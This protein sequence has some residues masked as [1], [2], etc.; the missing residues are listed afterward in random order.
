[1]VYRSPWTPELDKRLMELWLI[2]GQT[3]QA[4]GDIIG[5][6]KHSVFRRLKRMGLGDKKGD[7]FS[8]YQMMGEIS[9][10]KEPHFQPVRHNLP[11]RRPPHS[12]STQ[13]T[14]LHWSDVHFPFHDPRAVNI[15]YQINEDLKPDTLVCHGD[16]A[17]MWQLSTHRPPMETKLRAD[18]IDIQE[19]LDMTSE[20][21]AQMEAIANPTWKIFMMGNHEDRWNRMLTKIQTDQKYRQLLRIPKIAEVM[22]LDYLIG[23][24]EKG[25]HFDDYLEG[26]RQLLHERLL[27]IHGYA[28]TIWASR[29]HLQSY[30]TNVMF[31]HSHRIQNFTK[32]D[33]NGSISSWNIGCLCDLRP[34]WRQRPNWQQGFAVVN[35]SQAEGKWYF[36]VEQIRIHDGICIWRDKTYKA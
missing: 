15:L 28:A 9:D 21:L 5:M 22:S 31:G 2:E 32:T 27:V 4:I 30:G 3:Q 26:D 20:H 19:T 34:H 23:L 6:S 18:Q 14:S 17:D 12:S 36:N 11:E 29:K 35:W 1:M 10:L 8:Y 24:T 7:S 13:Q 33:L 25:W 16:V